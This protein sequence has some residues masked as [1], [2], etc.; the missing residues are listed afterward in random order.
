LYAAGN[1]SK[2]KNV[3]KHFENAEK[4]AVVRATGEKAERTGKLVKIAEEVVVGAVSGEQGEADKILNALRALENEDGHEDILA[5]A[6]E[7][8]LAIKESSK[9][10]L[11]IFNELETQ[12]NTAVISA[13]IA[14][15]KA[16]NAETARI[17][18]LEREMHINEMKMK[19]EFQR[20]VDVLE[21]DKDEVD[22]LVKS[23]GV[24]VQLSEEDEKKRRMK[25]A[26]EEAKRRNGHV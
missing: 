23:K 7:T 10:L 11:T 20:R 4:Q 21:Q 12:L 17:K 18:E 24:K 26:L 15:A 1:I 9:S 3:E 22:K 13:E 19:E 14:Q 16:E 8:L 5:R 6:R 2:M 25:V